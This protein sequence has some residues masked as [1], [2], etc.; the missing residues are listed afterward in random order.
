M[1]F[2]AVIPIQYIN[3]SFKS[4]FNVS[5]RTQGYKTKISNSNYLFVRIFIFFYVNLSQQKHF[6]KLSYN[7]ITIKVI[8]EIM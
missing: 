2:I 1:S 6:L 8:I 4:S 5:S 3:Y 7:L